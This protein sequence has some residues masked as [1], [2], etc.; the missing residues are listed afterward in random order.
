MNQYVFALITILCGIFANHAVAQQVGPVESVEVFP[1]PPQPASLYSMKINIYED[2][3]TYVIRSHEVGDY[4]VIRVEP[5]IG[6]GGDYLYSET[7]HSS[8]G[9]EMLSFD[10]QLSGNGTA[11]LMMSSGV[12]S[13]SVSVLESSP[14]ITDEDVLSILVGA[15][16]HL[17]RLDEFM[18]MFESIANSSSAHVIITNHRTDVFRCRINECCVWEFGPGGPD[19]NCQ[20]C[21]D[22]NWPPLPPTTDCNGFFDSMYCCLYE[23]SRDYCRR[24]CRSNPGSV[25]A[26]S[27]EIVECVNPLR[28]LFR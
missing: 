9:A 10:W 2:H 26:G 17:D 5:G 19:S 25:I 14:E 18:A 6:L 22:Y 12:Q 11:Q 27:V 8:T 23:S 1:I 28:G 7:I 15:S 13:A 16:A 24:L 4:V 21:C 3:Y 20:Y